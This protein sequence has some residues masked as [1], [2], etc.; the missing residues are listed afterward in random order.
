M[1]LG[2]WQIEGEHALLGSQA[3][4]G[5]TPTVR[6]EPDASGRS[7]LLEPRLRH[8][9]DARAPSVH[10]AGSSAVMNTA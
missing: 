6:Q 2:Q 8:L 5:P 7:S 10:C 1:R 3:G 4:S 9:V